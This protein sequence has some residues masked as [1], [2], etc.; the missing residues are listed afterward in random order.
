SSSS[1]SV[2]GVRKRSIASS[3]IAGLIACARAAITPTFDLPYSP[4]SACSCR[5]VF[6]TQTSSASIRVSR[7]TPVRASASAAHEPTPPTPTTQ[8]CF[9][10]SASTLP[11]PYRRSTPAKRSTRFLSCKDVTTRP[12]CGNGAFYP[13]GLDSRQAD[14]LCLLP[15]HAETESK[16]CALP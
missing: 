5:L 7:P 6:E 3:R 1:S 11:S 16:R 15:S 2:D 9:C 13:A 10:A 4:S 8:T 14:G 12:G